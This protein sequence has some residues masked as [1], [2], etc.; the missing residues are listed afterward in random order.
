MLYKNTYR[1]E[2]FSL[3]GPKRFAHLSLNSAIKNF[4]GRP[5]LFNFFGR[6][7]ADSKSGDARRETVGDG[8][9]TVA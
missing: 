6:V 8:N 4:F 7:T 1:L 9:G 5:Y 3:T 2:L